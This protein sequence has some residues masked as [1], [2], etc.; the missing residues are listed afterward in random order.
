M[1]G[2][3]TREFAALEEKVWMDG[4]F[5]PIAHVSAMFYGDAK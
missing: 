5:S 4:E 1:P 3:G 2:G